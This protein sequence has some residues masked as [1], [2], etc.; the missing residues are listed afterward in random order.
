M[1]NVRV[2]Y[3]YNEKG[4]RTTATIQ[5]SFQVEA[6]TESAVA[7]AI[8]RRHRDRENIVILEIK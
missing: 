1:M 5:E 2:K 3:K 6:K 7:D 8:K 4:L